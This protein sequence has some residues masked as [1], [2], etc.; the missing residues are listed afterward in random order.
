ME[1][2]QNRM[3]ML[4]KFA[5][6]GLLLLMPYYNA[7]AQ[8]TDPQV[9][10]ARISATKVHLATGNTTLSKALA[11]ISNQSGLTITAPYYLSEHKLVANLED[12]S[13]EHALDSLCELNAWVW[14]IDA[15]GHILVD[16]PKV[17]K[18]H[19]LTELHNALRNALPVAYQNFVASELN[20][21]DANAQIIH[22][23]E[24]PTTNSI[25]MGQQTKDGY[26][27]LFLH[28]KAFLVKDRTDFV[29]AT[30]M[31]R[32]LSGRRLEYS[33]LTSPEK[34]A[35][36]TAIVVAVLGNLKQLSSTWDS[37]V[38]P[39]ELDLLQTRIKVV[40]G[41]EIQFDNE[42]VDATGRHGVGIGGGI[43]D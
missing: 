17:L 41:K 16:R 24:D 10:K 3:Q 1:S 38:K 26:L 30:I 29:S 32:L 39:F 37:G 4:N 7:T 2:K 35:L 31:P 36:M 8:D 40:A 14:T 21:T 20:A 34:E 11:S 15:K 19:N 33:L 6:T 22:L 12:I 9:A 18:P 27:K 42:Y 13:A 25:Q 5:F 28:P 23:Y 43:K